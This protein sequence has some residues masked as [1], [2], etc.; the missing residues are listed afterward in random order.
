MRPLRVFKTLK[1]RQS[2][3]VELGPPTI[4][5]AGEYENPLSLDCAWQGEIAFDHAG[6]FNALRFIT[7][8]VLAVNKAEQRTADWFNQYLIV[9]MAEPLEVQPGDRLEVDFSY[10]AG[11][12]L[13]SLQPRIR[14]P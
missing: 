14:R 4:Y 12:P 3:T 6:Q 9:P 8:N 2:R 7:K 13:A 10:W 1:Q 11:G 5:Q